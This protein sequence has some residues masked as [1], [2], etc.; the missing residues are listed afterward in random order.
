MQD[1][2]ERLQKKVE[3]FEKQVV[4]E[5]DKIDINPHIEELPTNSVASKPSDTVIEKEEI[6]ES[7]R[8]KKG[9]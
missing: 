2:N 6:D 8:I 3:T 1:N 9:P 5:N 7:G 4:K